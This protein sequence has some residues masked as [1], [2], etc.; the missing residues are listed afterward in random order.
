MCVRVPPRYRGEML[1]GQYYVE[2][3]RLP[4]REV[5]YCTAA[6]YCREQQYSHDQWLSSSPHAATLKIQDLRD[7]EAASESSFNHEE[8]RRYR[9]SHNILREY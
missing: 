3:V 4:I 5:P 2:R 7:S 8:L 6:A 9:N 1:T